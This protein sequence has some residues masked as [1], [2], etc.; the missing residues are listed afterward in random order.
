MSE[1]DVNAPSMSNL[2]ELL[3][4]STSEEIIL[5]NEPVPTI[6]NG[7][8]FT[9][10]TRNSSDKSIVGLCQLCLPKKNGN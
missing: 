10:V 7:K 3:V 8:Y 2:S 4:P 6:L 9:V 1:Y 5:P